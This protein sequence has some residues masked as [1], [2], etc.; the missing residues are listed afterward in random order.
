MP[1]MVIEM[2]EHEK[3]ETA[4]SRLMKELCEARSAHEDATVAEREAS[5]RST[6]A[7]NRLN[8]AQ[9]EFDEFVAKLKKSSHGHTDWGKVR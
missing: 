8:K 1:V 5:S 3:D 6:S 7:I 2:D 9:K 4:L